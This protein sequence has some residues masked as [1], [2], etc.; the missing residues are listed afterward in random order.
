MSRTVWSLAVVCCMSL[1]TFSCSKK[2]AK[3]SG[4]FVGLGGKTVYLE[5]LSADR[6]VIDSAKL[7][8]DGSFSFKYKFSREEPVFLN[9]R[10]NNSFVT[11][12]VEPGERVNLSALS[13]IANSYTVEGSKGSELIRE[14]N[15]ETANTYFEIDSLYALYGKTTDEEEKAEIS[16]EIAKKYIAQKQQNIRFVVVNANSLAGIAALY[17]RLPN[18]MTIFGDANDYNYFKLVADSLE[19]KYPKSV[20]VRSLIQDV[21]QFQNRNNVENM[22]ANSLS[23]AAAPSPELIMQDMLG[24]THKLSDLKGKVTLVSFWSVTEPS[25]R[26]LNRELMDI[27]EV[28]HPKGFEVYQISLDRSKQDWVNA[29]ND[30]KLPWISVCDFKGADSPAVASYN[31]TAIPFNYILDRDGEIVGKNLWGSDLTRKIEEYL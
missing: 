5:Q 6:L 25:Q 12:L 1:L 23:N 11:L 29:V 19:H 30:Q 4:N 31:V 22:L 9:L 13:N 24:T 26:M 28:Y 21:E 20:H 10:V 27:Y 18:G 17:Q 3:I 7:G 14:L 15:K 2:S 16:R 8:T